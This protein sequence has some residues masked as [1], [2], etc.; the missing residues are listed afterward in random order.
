MS[1][2]KSDKNQINSLRDLQLLMPRL[3]K[4]TAGNDPL[5]LAALANPIL[6]LAELG[7]DVSPK[8]AREIEVRARFGAE[9]GAAYEQLEADLFA[10]AGAEFDPAEPEAVTAVLEKLLP[11]EKSKTAQAQKTAL[12][13]TQRKQMLEAA[14][15]LPPGPAGYTPQRDPLANFAEAH[16]IVPLLV[17]WRQ[18]ERRA[19]R[20]A[21]PETFQRVLTGE[22]RLPITH[23]ELNMQERSRRK[24]SQKKK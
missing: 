13:R 19:P 18:L 8:A 1:P 2:Q 14:R 23:V 11:V 16:P 10:A 15:Q 17:R 5:L 3:L 7:Y 21:P 4:E 22:L 12:S 6:A 24:E 20:F 9:E